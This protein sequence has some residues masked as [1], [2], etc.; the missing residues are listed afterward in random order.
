[1]FAI[2][3]SVSAHKCSV[4]TIFFSFVSDFWN[5]C[6]IA[7][8]VFICKLVQ[9]D[10]FRILFHDYSVP[11]FWLLWRIAWMASI[12]IFVQIYNFRI[13]FHDYSVPDFWFM[14]R[15]AERHSYVNLFKLIISGYYFTTIPYLIFDFCDVS[16]CSPINGCR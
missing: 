6:R 5:L 8:M 12:C 1:M 4:M 16:L 10:N 2:K 14:W 15:I 11:D 3:I 13:L 7:G 9:I